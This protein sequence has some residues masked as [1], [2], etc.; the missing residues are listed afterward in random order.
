M[1]RKEAPLRGCDEFAL[2]SRYVTSEKAT[3]HLGLWLG[4]VE[5]LT[6]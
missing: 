1:K 6:P 2:V 5:I 3:G 4:I